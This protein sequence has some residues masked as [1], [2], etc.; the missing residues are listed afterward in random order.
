MQEQVDNWNYRHHKDITYTFLSLR[1]RERNQAPIFRSEEIHRCFCQS[2]HCE[3][4][5]R[6]YWSEIICSCQ[7]AD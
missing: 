1:D 7:K 2:F 5:T 6:C 4:T 3:K